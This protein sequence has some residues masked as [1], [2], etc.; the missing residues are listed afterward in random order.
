MRTSASP[1][2]FAGT[3]AYGF[4]VMAFLLIE[5]GIHSNADPAH[6]IPPRGWGYPYD[7]AGEI[8]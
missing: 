1:G 8:R 2:S 6:P 3:T 4:G 5:V 7:P